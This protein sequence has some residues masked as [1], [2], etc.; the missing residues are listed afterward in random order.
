M[1]VI[2]ELFKVFNK[3][4]ARSPEFMAAMKEQH[5][6]LS[7]DPACDSPIPLFMEQ[8]LH[9][10]QLMQ[11]DVSAIHVWQCL[12]T[13]ELQAACFKSL[14]MLRN[15]ITDVQKHFEIGCC[16]KQLRMLRKSLRMFATDVEKKQLRVLRKTI[17]DVS[18]RYGC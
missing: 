10:E 5:V 11:N 2:V 12:K 4:G 9:E 14:R 18:N 8:I 7:M 3:S 13:S 17:T 15:K 6:F 16:E 1:Q